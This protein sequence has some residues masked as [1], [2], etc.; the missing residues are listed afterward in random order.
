MG[1]N[2]LGSFG[3]HL[4]GKLGKAPLAGALA[5]GLQ[6]A[7]EP[8]ARVCR[9]H[10]SCGSTQL[11]GEGLEGAGVVDRALTLLGRWIPSWRPVAQ[12]RRSLQGAL[13]N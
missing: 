8:G 7:S 10:C 12:K 3:S 9:R 11:K 2:L 4:A 6:F 5:R 1:I 13:L